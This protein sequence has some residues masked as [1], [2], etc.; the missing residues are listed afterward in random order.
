MPLALNLEFESGISD[1]KKDRMITMLAN[2]HQTYGTKNAKWAVKEDFKS[3]E[4]QIIF[5]MNKLGNK[6][7]VTDTTTLFSEVTEDNNKRLIGKLHYNLVAIIKFQ[8]LSV[9]VLLVRI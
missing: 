2:K 5:H 4:N 9:V 1:T 8:M 7:F 6:A 3:E